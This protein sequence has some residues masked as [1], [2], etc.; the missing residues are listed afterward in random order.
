M[1]RASIKLLLRQIGE[2][3]DEELNELLDKLIEI[4]ELI[5]KLNKS[6]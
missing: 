5:E 6:L 3:N 2:L 4:E 1:Q